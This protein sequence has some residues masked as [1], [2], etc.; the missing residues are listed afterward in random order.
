MKQRDPFFDNAKFLLI[1]LVLIGHVIT[2]N[3]ADNRINLATYNWIYTFHMPLFIFISG[4][5]TN[6]G[7]SSF[8]LNV[9]KLFESFV[10]FSLFQIAITIL[11]RKKGKTT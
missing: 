6:I 3:R 4:Y 1:M 2:I 8:W 5:F 7:K 11:T 10:I 9:L